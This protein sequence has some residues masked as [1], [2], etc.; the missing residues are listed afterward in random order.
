MTDVKPKVLRYCGTRVKTFTKEKKKDGEF[1]T[2]MSSRRW[3]GRKP[4]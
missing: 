2:I 1:I 4:E 3:V